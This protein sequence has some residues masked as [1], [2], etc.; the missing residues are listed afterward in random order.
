MAKHTSNKKRK[1]IRRRTHPGVI[2]AFN[3]LLIIILFCL[4]QIIPYF[5]NN[6]VSQSTYQSLI[7]DY[8]TE[9][10]DAVGEDAEWWA[11]V[12]IDF[13]ALHA[14]NSDIVAWIRFDNTDA[15]PIDY[16]ILYDGDN[17]SYI[18]TSI[19]GEYSYEGCLFIE[20]NNA[21]DFSD[22]NTIL[23]GHAMRNNHMFGSLKYYRQDSSFV[24]ENG[25]FTIY[26]PGKA[27]R[28]RIFSYFTTEATSDVYQIGFTAGS[29]TYETYLAYLVSNAMTD[30]GYT[31][32]SDEPIVI[33]STCATGYGTSSQRFVVFGACIDEAQTD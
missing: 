33:L 1:R 5:W 24:T 28:Y 18:H 13:D 30:C 22:M 15:V 23:Y 29:S 8:V 12:S 2:I 4:Y 25:Y 10:G 11:L 26:M 31:P 21:G 7:N 20:E 19:Y 17:T 16:P 6:H 14:I 27:M 3:A 32:T 9:S